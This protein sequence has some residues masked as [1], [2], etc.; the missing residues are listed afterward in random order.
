MKSTSIQK[1]QDQMDR[2]DNW[3]QRITLPIAGYPSEWRDHYLY[4]AMRIHWQELNNLRQMAEEAEDYETCVAIRR[5][6]ASRLASISAES[7]A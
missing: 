7:I 3:L 4:W 5:H 1:I 6:L 2:F